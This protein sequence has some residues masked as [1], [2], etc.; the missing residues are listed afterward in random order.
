L[1]G[2]GL[3]TS[4]HHHESVGVALHVLSAFWQ[5][6]P[7]VTFTVMPILL[8]L[9]ILAG[10]VIIA[11][12]AGYIYV[13]LGGTAES[14]TEGFPKRLI[15]QRITYG[16][17]GLPVTL[18]AVIFCRAMRDRGMNWRWL[19][20]TGATLAFF[21]GMTVNLTPSTLIIGFS[22]TIFQLIA[23]DH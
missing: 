11:F 16:G 7:I 20:L 6:H 17:I 14:L 21:P 2:L 23:S 18:S 15:T 4:A 10:L 3:L 12:I 5:K 19:L 13:G 1:N 22:S 8:M 9:G